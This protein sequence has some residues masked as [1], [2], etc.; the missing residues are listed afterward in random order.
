MERHCINNLQALSYGCF[1]LRQ[2]E[3]FSLTHCCGNPCGRETCRLLNNAFIPRLANTGRDNSSSVI[4]RKLTVAFVQSRFISGICNHAG[5]EIIRNQQ[6]RDAAKVFISMD[7]AQQPILLLH[8]SASFRVDVTAAR[9]RGNKQICLVFFT[10]NGVK[11][12][13]R[14]ACP[15]DLHS[16]AGLVSNAHGCFCHASPTTVF[17]TELRAH[18]RLLTVCAAFLTIFLPQQRK[19]YAFL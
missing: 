9:E 7:M 1:Y 3:E 6:P 12:R 18:I 11:I 8:I 10:G 2:R 14:F 15:I 16:V 4:F 13:N 19:R 17:V 5:F